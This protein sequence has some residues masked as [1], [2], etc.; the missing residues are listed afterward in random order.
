MNAHTTF[1]DLAFHEYANLFPML[2]G[3]ALDALRADIREHG[4]RDPIVI[5]HGE[6]LDGRNRYTCA[7]DLGIEAPSIAFEGDDPLAFVISHNLHRRHLTESQRASIAARVANMGQGHRSDKEHSANLPKVPLSQRA[8]AGMLNVSERS[9]RAA[10][11]THEHAPS[12]ITRALDDGRI[13]ASLASKVA[14]LPDD[15]K[16][17]IGDTAGEQT[18]AELRASVSAALKS[19]PKR[20]TNKNPVHVKDAQRD[21]VIGFAGDCRRIAETVDVAKLAQWRGTPSMA[22]QAREQASA[23]KRALTTFIDEWDTY[24]A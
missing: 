7:R 19:N 15:A 8:A 21:A 5:Y 23:A 17:T 22:K 6:I 14:D 4:V 18:R 24:D 11:K 20:P 16:T 1:K 3:D 2:H 12:E 13:S 10:K 9:L